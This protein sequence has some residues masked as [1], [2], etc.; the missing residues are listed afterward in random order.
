[1]TSSVVSLAELSGELTGSRAA[2][3]TDMLGAY[4][5]KPANT[6]EELRR[7]TSLKTMLPADPMRLSQSQSQALFKAAPSNVGGNP[8]RV[9]SMDAAIIA[10]ASRPISTLN[11]SM[12]GKPRKPR[13]RNPISGEDPEVPATLAASSSSL[14]GAKPMLFPERGSLGASKARSSGSNAGAGSAKA[15]KLEYELWCAQQKRIAA[16]RELRQVMIRGRSRPP[17][18]GD[19]EASRYQS[20]YPQ[21]R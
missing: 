16:E 15:S 17:W 20:L 4:S 11:M 14:G 5:L 18:I 7:T 6:H 19:G 21:H 12:G 9:N 2:L 10:A 8:G 13:T 1:M 3:R